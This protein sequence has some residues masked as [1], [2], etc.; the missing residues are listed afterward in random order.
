MSKISEGCLK[1][2]DEWKSGKHRNAID[3]YERIGRPFWY[4]EMVG[5][6]YERR[7]LVSKAMA[8]YEI[9][10]NAYEKMGILPLPG[11][12][13]ALFWLGKW[14]NKQN[15]AKAKRCLVLYLKAEELENDPAFRIKHKK[16]AQDLLRGL[17]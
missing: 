11:G 2:E 14:Y 4:A 1:F 7:G 9:L 10:I 5:K 17:D 6:Y 8:E 16:R 15:P 3:I 12:P 13:E